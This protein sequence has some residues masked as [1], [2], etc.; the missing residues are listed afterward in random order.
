MVRIKDNTWKKGAAT[1]VKK[2]PKGRVK[3]ACE[4][5][6]YAGGTLT[7]TVDMDNA[8]FDDNPNEIKE[9]LA[10]VA[11]QVYNNARSGSVRDSNGNACGKFEVA[12]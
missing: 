4:E 7:I 6:Q 8:A 2:A 3:P 11:A 1:A 10:K 5:R 9:I 12:K